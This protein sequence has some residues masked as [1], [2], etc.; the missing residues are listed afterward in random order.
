MLCRPPS[1]SKSLSKSARLRS[2][3]KAP[4]PDQKLETP[5]AGL[6]RRRVVRAREPAERPSGAA[7]RRIFP[8]AHAHKDPRVGAR[9]TNLDCFARKGITAGTAA[10]DIA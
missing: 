1:S 2:L 6:T 8:D 9:F 3:K 4:W 7:R 10:K 5:L